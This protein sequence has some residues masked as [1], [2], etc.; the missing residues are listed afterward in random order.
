MLLKHKSIYFLNVMLP[1]KNE[2]MCLIFSLLLI[3][4]LILQNFLFN[5]I[6]SN[7]VSL[8]VILLYCNY[9]F[10]KCESK[11]E[12]PNVHTL[13]KFIEKEC[14]TQANCRMYRCKYVYF[15]QYWANIC[16]MF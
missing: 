15:L 5:K 16:K 2:S 6:Q 14:K 10:Y 13:V 8:N 11:N 4:E 12:A 9:Y 7:N 3:V 1:G